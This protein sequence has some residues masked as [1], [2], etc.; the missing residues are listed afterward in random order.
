MLASTRQS[1]DLLASPQTKRYLT[2]V[3]G[4]I[5]L[6]KSAIH[7]APRTDG[8]WVIQTNDGTLAPEDAAGA[9]RSL[10]VIERCFHTL[11]TTQLKLSPVYHRLPCRIEAHVK[12]CVMAYL[13]N[14][15]SSYDV[16]NL[17]PISV[18]FWALCRQVNFTHLLTFS[19]S[20][21][22]PPNNSKHSSKSFKFPSLTVFWPPFLKD[23]RTKN[24]R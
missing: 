17:G 12:I 20:E 14:E 7:R 16:G 6:D 8:K 19:F 13:S 5:Q 15:L 18:V 2:V 1:I 11:K 21:I 3:G 22:N 9:Y 4:Q 23:T 24:P 10:A